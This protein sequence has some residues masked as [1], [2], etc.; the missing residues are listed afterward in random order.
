MSNICERSTHLPLQSF[1]AT[2]VSYHSNSSQRCPP[3]SHYSLLLHLMRIYLITAIQSHVHFLFRL[4]QII[5]PIWELP[6]RVSAV[7]FMESPSHACSISR[8]VPSYMNHLKPIAASARSLLYKDSTVLQIHVS[9]QYSPGTETNTDL[10]L[11]MF[12]HLYIS[13]NGRHYTS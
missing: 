10:S 2:L 3:S 9:C 6:S 5:V 4:P 8:E 1:R 7:S 11:R 13:F 12:S